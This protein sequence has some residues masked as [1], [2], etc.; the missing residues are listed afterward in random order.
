MGS[1]HL[2]ISS[3]NLYFCSIASKIHCICNARFTHLEYM[4]GKSLR[5]ARNI[6]LM[7]VESKAGFMFRQMAC[8]LM[9][10]F[11]LTSLLVTSLISCV[12]YQVAHMFTVSNQLLDLGQNASCT[13]DTYT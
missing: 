10:L 3:V 7:L 9:S 5:G 11:G 2:I 12:K 6:V 1:R 8:S 4:E 13:P